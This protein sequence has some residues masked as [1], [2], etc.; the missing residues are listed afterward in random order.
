MTRETTTA[1]RNVRISTWGTIHA[2]TKRAAAATSQD[3]RSLNGLILGRTIRCSGVAA[4]AFKVLL[5][6]GDALPANT[7]AC[8]A[9]R[10]RTPATGAQRPGED[11]LDHGRL[12]VG[13]VLDVRPL[14]LRE[15]TL[16]VLVQLAV[17]VVQPEPVAERHHP[18]DLGAA[19]REGVDVHVRVGTLEQPVLVPVRLA[20]AQH[21]V[22]GLER[23][24]IGPLVAGVGDDENDVDQRLRGEAGYGRG[25]RV[26]DPQRRRPEGTSDPLRLALVEQRPRRVVLRE[27]NRR[28][29][30]PELADLG[31]DS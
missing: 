18:L 31:H 1:P 2:A 23:W 29:V 5:S 6:I 21:V 22:G 19:F 30:R 14:T 4:R 7:D 26:L 12:G 8:T 13:V 15:V 17:V 28:R 10:P 9:W 11:L 25:A 24:D 3:T 27:V 16:R 20:D